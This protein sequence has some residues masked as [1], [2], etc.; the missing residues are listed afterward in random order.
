[1]F[2]VSISGHKILGNFS[3]SIFLTSYILHDGYELLS[4][5]EKKY[6]YVKSFMPCLS[7]FSTLLCK[8]SLT[9]FII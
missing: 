9:L 5:S 8:L 7:P 2:M 4:Y 1:M 3:F 6:K